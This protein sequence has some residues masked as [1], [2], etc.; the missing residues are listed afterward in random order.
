V[1]HLLQRFGTDAAEVDSLDSI[2]PRKTDQNPKRYLILLLIHQA[3]HSAVERESEENTARGLTCY[4]RGRYTAQEALAPHPESPTDQ[5]QPTI[6]AHLVGVNALVAVLQDYVRRLIKTLQTALHEKLILRRPGSYD[7]LTTMH[8]PSFVKISTVSGAKHQIRSY[9]KS[10][11]STVD[12]CL[13]ERHEQADQP[14]YS[15]SKQWMK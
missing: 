9:E 3:N 4:H 8:R 1:V 10:S 14:C 7:Q 5:L 12:E 11:V 15:P 2:S 6:P 13:Q